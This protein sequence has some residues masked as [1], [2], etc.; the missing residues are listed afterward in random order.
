MFCFPS[1]HQLN[2]DR[3]WSKVRR[4]TIFTYYPIAASFDYAV[5]DSYF[6]CTGMRNTILCSNSDRRLSYT[7]FLVNPI[8]REHPTE[9]I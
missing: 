5:N 3:R 6:P 9:P 8:H 1:R 2:D 4:E 7:M